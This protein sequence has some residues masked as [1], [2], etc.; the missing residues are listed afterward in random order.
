MSQT[1]SQLTPIALLIDSSKD[2]TDDL[3]QT[4]FPTKTI[5]AFSTKLINLIP[6]FWKDNIKKQHNFLKSVLCNVLGIKPSLI[7]QNFDDFY[8]FL[9]QEKL[10]N[11]QFIDAHFIKCCHCN[12]HIKDPV[13]LSDRN[14]V[15]RDC[16]IKDFKHLTFST[17]WEY[18]NQLSKIDHTFT[19]VIVKNDRINSY[20]HT[21]KATQKVGFQI[22][23]IITF[24]KL[25][26]YQ[27]YSQDGTLHDMKSTT[28][29]SKISALFFV[30]SA[31]CSEY[32]TLKNKD[33]TKSIAVQPW[34]MLYHV[35]FHVDFDKYSRIEITLK[36]S[37]QTIKPLLEH[38]VASRWK[39]SDIEL[40]IVTHG[41][42]SFGRFNIFR[43]LPNFYTNYKP[44]IFTFDTVTQLSNGELD[45][46]VCY[47]RK[48]R[49]TYDAIRKVIKSKFE[50]IIVFV[51]GDDIFSMYDIAD[52]S[53]INHEIKFLRVVNF[54]STTLSKQ[55][56]D[57][58]LSKGGKIIN[59][60][61]L[62]DV[63]CIF[64]K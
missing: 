43:H 11:D 58:V 26:N 46:S 39:L 62:D 9:K 33:E 52:I 18:N 2:I 54:S 30:E 19:I 59:F 8:A 13:I 5:K 36:H 64:D 51:C 23:F 24:N 14:I 61:S 22:Q 10:K 7:E 55:F 17:N 48:H 27:V 20:L 32:V 21:V 6:N 31:Y 16:A 1:A 47:D 29:I 3:I 35:L 49:C 4:E 63:F 53:R 37:G 40:Q 57:F 15:D 56:S 38:N 25:D 12:K 42:F 60:K 44:S 50:H 45:F 34:M 28:V 41:N